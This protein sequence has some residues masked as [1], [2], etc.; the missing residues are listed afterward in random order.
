MNN[1][2]L[3][4]EFVELKELLNGESAKKLIAGTHLSVFLDDEAI[5]YVKMMKE[6]YRIPFY[7]S[8]ERK[9]FTLVGII[10]NPLLEDALARK[11]IQ[12]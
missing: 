9:V 3:E 11:L 7:V 1:T 6:R 8:E 5:K 12:V 10:Y 2:K 4:I